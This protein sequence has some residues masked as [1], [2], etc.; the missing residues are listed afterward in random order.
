[1]SNQ[2]GGGGNAN[3]SANI[4]WRIIGGLFCSAMSISSGLYAFRL[5][6]QKQAL[7]QAPSPQVRILLL[8]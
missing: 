1:M 2:R 3:N 8:T 4:N 5:Q 6:R 7:E